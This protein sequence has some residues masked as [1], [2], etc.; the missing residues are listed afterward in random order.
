MPL[1]D[2]PIYWDISLTL[3]EPTPDVLH[4]AGS[5]FTR[6]FPAYEVSVGG[7]DLKESYMPPD[8]SLTYITGCLSSVTPGIPQTISDDIPLL[9]QGTHIL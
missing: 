5:W 7:V 2:F 4:V 8:S 3:N 6:C 9:T 1:Y